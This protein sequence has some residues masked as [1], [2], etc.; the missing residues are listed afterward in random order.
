VGTNFRLIWLSRSLS[1]VGDGVIPAA[2]AL[3]VAT[4]TGS[5]SALALVL[6]CATVPKL[7][8]L[9]V[10]GAVADRWPA[11]RIAIVGDLVRGVVQAVVAV[12]LISGRFR[13]IDLAVASAVCGAAT[14]FA[15]PTNPPLVAASVGVEF[16]PRANALLGVSSNAGRV[17]GPALGGT[18]FLTVGAGW[19]FAADAAT[20]AL[21]AAALSRIR[22]SAKAF[23]QRCGRQPDPLLRSI[24]VGLS[25]VRRHT[26]LWTSLIGHAAW[27]L[28]ASMVTTLGP[29]IAV[30]KLGGGLVWVSVLQASAIGLLAGSVLATR[31]GAGVRFSLRITRPVMIA[32]LGL[33]IYAVPLAALALA[34]PVPVL[35]AAFAAAGFLNPVWDSAMQQHVPADKLARV[36]SLDMLAAFVATP[37]G[38][39]LAP[40][41]AATFGATPT[42]LSTAL[43]VVV[44]TAG[45]A[46]TRSVRTLRAPGEDQDSELVLQP[47]FVIMC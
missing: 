43:L 47:D 22:I 27:N 15:R 9:P 11:R 44:T 8:L 28:A 33:A 37:L 21:S 24:A 16:R 6:T 38:Y 10:G 25:E 23:N 7:V 39:A 3:A 42:L 26:W 19:A 45:T 35:V 2:L 40:L 46:A 14:A 41:V 32:N 20:F 5:A 12:E 13:L 4:A 31:L 36:A 1:V 30:R 18:L 17:L 34:A 29:L